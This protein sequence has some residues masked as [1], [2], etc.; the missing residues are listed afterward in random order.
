MNDKLSEIELDDLYGEQKELA[1]LIGIET[2]VKLVRLIGGSNIYI[3][4]ADKLVNIFRNKKIRSE[5]TGDNYNALAIKYGLSERRIRNI[6]NNIDYESDG[7]IMDD[8]QLTLFSYNDED[9]E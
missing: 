7:C 9:D 6:I 1:E 4:K 3:A 2:Y 8:N 5:F